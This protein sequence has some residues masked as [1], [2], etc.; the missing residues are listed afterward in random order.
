MEKLSTGLSSGTSSVVLGNFFVSFMFSASMQYVWD[1]IS[2]MQIVIMIPLENVRIPQ[3]GYI[4]FQQLMMI[5]AVELIPTELIYSK[6]SSVEPQPLSTTFEE[7][8][9]QHHLVLDN[10]GTLG[11]MFATL[12]LV[13]TFELVSRCFIRSKRCKRFSTRLHEKLYVGYLLRL[14]IQSYVVGIICCFLN[15][16]KLDF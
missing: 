8:G 9:F 3:N 12:P 13:Y 16:R 7:L 11:F 10:F 6:V 2:K 14:I 4:L 5:A 15:L 1:M